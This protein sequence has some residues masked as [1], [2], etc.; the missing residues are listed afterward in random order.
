[1]TDGQRP[2][3][4]I[5]S[6]PMQFKAYV[7]WKEIRPEDA[8]MISTDWDVEMYRSKFGPAHKSGIVILYN[9]TGLKTKLLAPKKKQ[10]R[11]Q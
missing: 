8:Y 4:V 1:M 2:V 6:G 5:C 3:A 7:Q 9:M 11:G 10:K